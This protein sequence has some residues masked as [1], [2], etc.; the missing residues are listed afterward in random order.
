MRVLIA[1]FL[2]T[3]LDVELQLAGTC[4]QAISLVGDQKY[5]AITLDLMMPGVGGLGVL[6]AIRGGSPNA[7]TPVI[8]V[9][10]V[11][12]DAT[13]QRCLA[14]GA[15][16]YHIKP[17]RRAELVSLVRAQLKAQSPRQSDG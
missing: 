13:V 5:D 11:G 4:E 15:N 16:A 2:G 7:A 9:S 8:M 3:D 17:I 1:R 14:A 12:D 10:S 6:A